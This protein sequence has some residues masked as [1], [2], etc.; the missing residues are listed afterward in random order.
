MLSNAASPSNLEE[1]IQS[2]EDHFNE[3]V[4]QTFDKVKERKLDVSQFRARLVTVPIKYREHHKE[5]FLKLENDIKKDESID[6]IWMKLS[7]YWDFLN[8][9][10][11]ENLVQKFEDHKLKANMKDYVK[12]LKEF[13]STTRVCDF[14]EY[15]TKVNKQLKR[16]HLKDIVF[17]FNQSWEECTLEDLESMKESISHKFF[18]PSFVIS[19][20]D[21]QPGSIIVTW[22]LP[23]VIASAIMEILETTYVSELC[24]ENG[25]ESITID[26]KEIIYSSIKD[27]EAYEAFLKDINFTMMEKYRCGD[28]H[29]RASGSV[30]VR[31]TSSWTPL[32]YYSLGYTLANSPSE[33]KLHF[34]SFGDEVIKEMCRGMLKCM[35]P[36]ESGKDIHAHFRGNI[37]VEGLKQFVKVPHHLLQRIVTLDFSSNKLD[38]KALDLLSQVIPALSRLEVLNISNNPIGEGGA[39]ELMRAL[40]HYKTP[41][42]ELL[43]NGTSLGEEDIQALCEILA[44]NLIE[45]LDING[46]IISIMRLH[47]QTIRVKILRVCR[48]MSV[49][50]CTSLASLLKHRMCQLK[51]LDIRAYSINSDGA[52]QLATALSE[53]K[54]V[55]K[56]NMRW[57]EDFGDVGAGAFGGMLRRNTVLRELELSY[58]GITSQGCD[59]LAGGVRAN[60]TLQVLDLSDNQIEE[61]GVDLMLTSLQNNMSLK[62]LLLPRIY[63][64]RQADP[65]VEWRGEDSVN[66][67]CV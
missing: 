33:W 3:I 46:P 16:H 63:K 51:E 44:D 40:S 41:L 7:C 60:S 53:N 56:V 35:K 28:V 61:N 11:L 59:R 55:V 38:K 13:R 48:P 58:C 14:A 21:I 30:I 6:H 20:K 12:R 57:N 49:D 43:L 1:K 2:L 19:I 47:V 64:R 8:Y 52:V 50:S 42:K 34:F 37:S 10:L 27:Y 18:L 23:T 9:T 66:M 29:V 45:L 25:I 32:D 65:R 54:S 15:C 22:T 24:N 31:S 62:I 17:K 26:G 67:L 5:F 39:V 36:S 4:L